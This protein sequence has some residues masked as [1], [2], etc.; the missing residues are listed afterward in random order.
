MD[1]LG[2]QK[3]ATLYYARKAEEIRKGTHVPHKLRTFGAAVEAYIRFLDER[4]PYNLKVFRDNPAKD[5]KVTMIPA[6][7]RVPHPTVAEMTAWNSRWDCGTGDLAIKYE[8]MLPKEEINGVY[9]VLL[10]GA[11]KSHA[12]MLTLGIWTSGPRIAAEMAENPKPVAPPKASGGA[13]APASDPVAPMPHTGK[14]PCCG[15]T[16]LIRAGLEACIDC[17]HIWLT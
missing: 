14:C 2:F 17:E 15:K 6:F 7:Y 3:Q 10:M 13:G 12:V 9:P 1:P 11:H 5:M 16:N 8:A 4:V